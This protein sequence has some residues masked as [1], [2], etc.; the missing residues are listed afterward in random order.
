MHENDTFEYKEYNNY[1]D[2]CTSNV[3]YIIIKRMHEREDEGDG[4]AYLLQVM[5]AFEHFL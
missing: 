4:C 3:L 2:I 1:Y 5:Q